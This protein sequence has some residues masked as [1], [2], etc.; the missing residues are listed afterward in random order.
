MK[1]STLRRL[2]GC[3]SV[4]V[5][6]GVMA[7]CSLVAPPAAAADKPKRSGPPPI[8]YTEFPNVCARCHKSDGRGGPAYGGFAAD[9]RATALDHESLVQIIT[10][11]IRDRGMP[12]FESVLTKREID[13]LAAYIVER[14]KGVYLDQAGNRITPE[15][16]AALKA[17]GAAN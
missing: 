8:V 1:I 4:V 16:A 17:K 13:G 14:I 5:S 2:T 10:V 15:E 9:L 11:G 12:E 3:L 6:C 7:A